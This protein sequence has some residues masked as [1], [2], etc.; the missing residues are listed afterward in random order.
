M[1]NSTVIM[2]SHLKSYTTLHNNRYEK[3]FTYL[4]TYVAKHT[5]SYITTQL[6]ICSFMKVQSR[7]TTIQGHSYVCMYDLLRTL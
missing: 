4:R 7:E 5:T 1:S 2:C 6:T 3:E